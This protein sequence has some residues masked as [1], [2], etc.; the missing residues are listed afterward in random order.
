MIWFVLDEN[1]TSDIFRHG[2]YSYP[3]LDV[4]KAERKS[5]N[6]DKLDD[7]DEDADAHLTETGVSGR[8]VSYISDKMISLFF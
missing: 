6:D 8:R 2:E 1:D 3:V 4:V 7:Y 5:V